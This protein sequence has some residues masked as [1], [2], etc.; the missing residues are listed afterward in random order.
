M[1]THI[2]R[3]GA[4]MEALVS[5]RRVAAFACRGRVACGYESRQG[6][7]IGRTASTRC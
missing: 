4:P 5:T 1:K 7:L 6:V 2:Q 3:I